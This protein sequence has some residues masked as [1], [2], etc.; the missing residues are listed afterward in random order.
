MDIDSIHLLN[1]KPDE[2]NYNWIKNIRNIGIDN[3]ITKWIDNNE[4]FRLVMIKVKKCY[5]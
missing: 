2:S 3:L 1:N 4:S 5:M